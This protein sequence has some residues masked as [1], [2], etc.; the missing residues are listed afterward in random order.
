M[1]DLL[2]SAVYL[3]AAQLP[4]AIGV[5]ETSSDMNITVFVDNVVTP[6]VVA[7]NPATTS[8]PG[9]LI[10]SQSGLVEGLHQLVVQLG[11]N[12][13][14]VFDHL[15]YTTESEA[16]TTPTSSPSPTADP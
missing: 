14:F 13:T 1:P 16:S 11:D 3:F 2:G 15:V 8:I 9:Q 4:R 12:S 5:N 10:F 7:S 6:T